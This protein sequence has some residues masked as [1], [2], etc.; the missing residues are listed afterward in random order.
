MGAL[1]PFTSDVDFY[2]VF[3]IWRFPFYWPYF[4]LV[5][6]TLLISVNLYYVVF[7]LALKSEG[8]AQVDSFIKFRLE[9]VLLVYHVV[10]CSFVAGE[11]C[12]MKIKC[13][14]LKIGRD[15]RMVRIL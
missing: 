4:A 10:L 11:S 5:I 3:R 13:F 2:M 7:R 14:F 12:C 15:C 1:V 9:A 8:Y 6:F